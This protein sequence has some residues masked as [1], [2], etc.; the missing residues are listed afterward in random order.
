MKISEQL[1][2]LFSAEIEHEDGSH[3]VEI[4]AQEIELDNIE[5]GKTYRVALLSTPQD[6]GEKS[7]KSQRSGTRD[8]NLPEP[9][10]EEGER[11]R[12]EIEEIGDQG[13]GIAKVERGYVIVVP[14]TE[15]GE[16]V[17]IEITETKQN[18]AF[19]EVTERISYY[20]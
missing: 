16:R 5:A 3:S 14:D 9:P 1:R 6:S 20:D 17:E 11:R 7:Q 19:A 4:P 12:V 10:V 2:C 15:K 13:D 8:R 18:V